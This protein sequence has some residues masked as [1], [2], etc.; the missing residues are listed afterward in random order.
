MRTVKIIAV[1]FLAAFA[2]SSYARQA[3]AAPGSFVRAAD[4]AGRTVD[5][6]SAPRRIICVGPGTLRLITYLEASDKVAAIES[7][8]EKDAPAGRPYMIA[9]PELA[10]LPE[11][12]RASPMPQ[13]DPEA[14]LSVNPD[15]IFIS[16]VESRAADSLEEKTD[17]PVVVLSYG[18]LATFDNED[19][20]SSLRLAGRILGKPG[21]AEAVVRFIEDCEKDLAAR[22]KTAPDNERPEVYVGGLGYR[23]TCGITSTEYSYPAFELL[24]ARNAAAEPGRRGHVFVDKEKLLEW[25][26]DIIFIDGGGMKIVKDDYRKDPEFYESLSAVKSGNVHGLFPYNHYTTNIDTALAD[27]Y[28]IGKVIY[29]EGFAD[30]DPARKADEIY[31]FFVGKPVYGNMRDDWKEAF[32]KVRLNE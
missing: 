27:A 18:S 17:I 21:R 25:D 12:S 30:I 31:T 14:I 23:G 19:L 7:G 26:P 15:V 5:I 8:F 13:P 3:V 20:F 29:P 2:V 22:S 16:Y 10:G 28:Y 32:G 1:M 4:M 11:I 6:P 24:N 9:H